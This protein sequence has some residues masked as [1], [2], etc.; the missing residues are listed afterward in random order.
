MGSQ[1]CKDV[2][3][4]IEAIE[5]LGALVES[6]DKLTNAVNNLLEPDDKPTTQEE[7]DDS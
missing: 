1:E 5:V 6:V 3:W 4:H 2:D 7:P